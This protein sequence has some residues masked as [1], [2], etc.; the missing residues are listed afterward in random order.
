M[1]LQWVLDYPEYML[2]IVT[3]IAFSVILLRQYRFN[4]AP[5]YIASATVLS[6]RLGIA[7]FHGKYSSGYNH[8]VTFRLGDNDTLELY[9][10]REEY[11]WLTEGLQGT[12][13]WQ[14]DNLLSFD[15]EE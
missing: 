5:E 7:G 1:I 13:R 15:T 12:L 9:V 8:L 10:S 3:V 6:R 2:L 14:N 4:K 11:S